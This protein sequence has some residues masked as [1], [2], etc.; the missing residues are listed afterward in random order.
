M[1]NT[2]EYIGQVGQDYFVLKCLKYKKNGTFLEI[3]SNNYKHCNNTYLLETVY[4]WNGIM[5]E[6]DSKHLNE[7]KLFRQNS[8]H[9]IQDSTTINFLEEFQKLSFPKNIDYLQIDLDVD[10][11]STLTVLENL[12][13][14]VMNDYTFAVVTFE[15][16]IYRGDHY[17]TRETS[18]TIFNEKGYIR[19]FSDIKDSGNA[20]EDWYIHPTLVDMNY[21]NKIKTDISLEYTD[22]LN[23]LKNN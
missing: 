1:T 13:D 10:N 17:N 22:I 16:D 15:H 11:R 3:G 6:Y 20:F 7:Y 2:N 21:I 18:R 19:V 5:V 4:N 14:Q 23:I 9:I 12:Y 8:H